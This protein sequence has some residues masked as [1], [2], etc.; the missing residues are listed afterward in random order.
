[1]HRGPKDPYLH[2]LILSPFLISRLTSIPNKMA[3][4]TLVERLKNALSNYTSSNS[5]TKNIEDLLD[6]TAEESK[7]VP[8]GINCNQILLDTALNFSSEY[9]KADADDFRIVYQYLEDNYQEKIGP[10][11]FKNTL[12]SKTDKSNLKCCPRLIV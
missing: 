1:M 12:T 11:V 9:T 3:E 4:V 10:F 8:G 6:L 5:E 7:T 2:S